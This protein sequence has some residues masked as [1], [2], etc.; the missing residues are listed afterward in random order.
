MKE[1]YDNKIVSVIIPV[2]NSEKFIG[3]TINSVLNQ[4][5]KEIE[6]VLVDD[7]SKDN[8]RKIIEQFM[9]KHKNIVY[10][11]QEKNEGAAVARNTALDIAKGRYIAFLDSDDLW[12]PQK[13]EKQLNLMQ[14]KNAAFSYTAYEIVDESGA[15]IKNKI[16]IIKELKYKQLLK[17][18]VVSTPAVVIDRCIIGSLKMPNRRTGQDYA[19]WLLLL[20]KVEIA[21]GLDESLAKIRKREG[22]LSKNKLQNIKDVWEVQTINEK[23][24][25]VRATWNTLNYLLN[26]VIKRFF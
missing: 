18:T 12:Y 15:L 21:Y 13:V 16:K 1:L 3:E 17:R 7:C 20:R 19:Y 25:K 23:I 11:L 2:Y 4:T 24:P 14:E 10:H 6:I 8:S 9:K 5:Y 22:S 26:V